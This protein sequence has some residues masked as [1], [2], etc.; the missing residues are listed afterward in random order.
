MTVKGMGIEIY[1]E[2]EREGRGQINWL[3]HILIAFTDIMTFVV[4][5]WSFVFFL[6]L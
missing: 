5:Q 6:G 2:L 1:V 3:G 4:L